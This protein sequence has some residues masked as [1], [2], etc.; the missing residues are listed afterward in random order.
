MSRGRIPP[1]AT[2]ARIRRRSRREA[3][4]IPL[5]QAAPIILQ[6]RAAGTPVEALLAVHLAEALPVRMS[7]PAEEVAVATSAVVVA[8]AAA[9]LVAAVQ[10]PQLEAITSTKPSQSDSG[11]TSLAGVAPSAF[12]T[13]HNAASPSTETASARALESIPAFMSASAI[14]AVS[15]PAARKLFVS[16][17]RFNANTCLRNLRNCSRS[18]SSS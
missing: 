6:P 14:A 12:R 1:Q 17:F 7:V 18:T 4:T 3:A 13:L 9:T 8:V 16:V 5:R 2:P 15:M 10:L 11:A